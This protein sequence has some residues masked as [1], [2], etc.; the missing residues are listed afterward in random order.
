MWQVSCSE[1]WLVAHAGTLKKSLL[2]RS[3]FWCE[4][5]SFESLPYMG[6][7]AC[8]YWERSRRRDS[9]KMILSLNKK[10]LQDQHD[11][12]LKPGYNHQT[13]ISRHDVS[14]FKDTTTIPTYGDEAGVVS[15]RK[16]SR[17]PNSRTGWCSGLVTSSRRALPTAL[18]DDF[19]SPWQ[20]RMGGKRGMGG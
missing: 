18:F 12:R 8:Q 15:Y 2:A 10:E 17:R 9:R 5:R 14:Q 1:K 7:I 6:N 3:S 16:R 4:C 19:E 20:G 11:Q 13:T